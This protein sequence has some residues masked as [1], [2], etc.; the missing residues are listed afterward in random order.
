MRKNSDRHI[1]TDK[2]HVIKEKAEEIM[3]TGIKM[4]DAYHVACAVY[5]SCDCFLTTDDRLLKYYTDE[6]KVLNPIDFIRRTLDCSA[7][8]QAVGEDIGK[9]SRGG[10]FVDIREEFGKYHVNIVVDYRGDW[11][12]WHRD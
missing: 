7:I 5:A 8:E 6:I 11:S 12:A 3:R 4:K 9:T 1:D 2:A 10:F